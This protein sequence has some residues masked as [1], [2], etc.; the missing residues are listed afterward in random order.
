MWSSF[1]KERRQL[2]E[3]IFDTFFFML[4]LDS[5]TFPVDLNFNRLNGRLIA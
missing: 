4:I 1:G 2:I 5:R 3:F